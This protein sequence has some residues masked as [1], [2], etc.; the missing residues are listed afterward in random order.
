MEYVHYVSLIY[1]LS[2]LVD[3]CSPYVTYVWLRYVHHVDHVHHII[4][5]WLTYVHHMSAMFTVID[6]LI[7]EGVGES[8]PDDVNGKL[9]AIFRD[10]MKIDNPEDIK[11]VRAHQL[12]KKR[13]GNTTKPRLIIVKFHWVWR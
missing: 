2:Y 10:K 1:L 7:F 6:N 5:G 9:L 13:T 11:I 8:T 12:G 3:I 4:T